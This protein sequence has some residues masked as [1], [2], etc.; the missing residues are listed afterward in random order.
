M[1]IGGIGRK[2]IG[3][4]LLHGR[5][6]VGVAVV[7][8]LCNR[9]PTS[10]TPDR[11]LEQDR[12]VRAIGNFTAGQVESV[13]TVIEIRVEVI[14]GREAAAPAPDRPH[15]FAPA[16]AWAPPARVESNICCR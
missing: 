16:Q 7:A 10:D 9:G 8:S 11:G 4:R 14:L 12:N 5:G 3:A 2:S 15:L 13:E 1:H 6:R